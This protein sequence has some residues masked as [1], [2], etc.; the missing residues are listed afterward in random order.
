MT[1]LQRFFNLLRLDKKDIVQIFSYAIFSGL[2]SLSL[3]LGIQAIINFIQA[4]RISVSWIVLVVLV[5]IGVIFAGILSLMQLR[6]SENLQQKIFI[7]AA[8]EFAY[9]IPKLKFNEI[10]NSQTSELANRFFDTISIQKGTSKLLID[11]SSAFLQIFFGII[12]LSLYHPF[13]ILFGIFLAILLYL[14]FKFSYQSGLQTSLKE[15]KSKYKVANWLFELA[16]NNFSFK[17]PNHLEFALEKNNSLVTKYLG[18]REKHFSV[19]KRQFSQLLIFK[20]LIT[21]SLLLIGG[22][23]VINQ[24][25]NIGQFVAAEIIILLVINSVEKIILGLETFYDVLTSVEKIGQITD[26]DLEPV[27][28]M[29]IEN[30]SCFS[31]LSITL[32]NVEFKFEFENENVLENIDLEI[33]QGERILIEGENGSGKTTLIRLLSGLLQ[34]TKGH[35]IIN[36]DTYNKVN[37]N[38]YRKHFG[39]I[40]YGE[41]LFEGTILENIAFNQKIENSKLKWALE[42]VDLTSFIKTLPLGLQTPISSDGK[43]LSSSNM[44]KILIARSIINEPRILFFENA[45]DKTDSETAKKII[46]FLLH[47]D[48]KWTIIAVSKNEYF[49]EKCSRIITLNEGKIS[50]DFKKI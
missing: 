8:F 17:N 41:S 2:I 14:I 29:S 6:I 43:Q 25:M 47:N 32:E 19:I 50:K 35:F 7:R 13:F 27:E 37:I 15:S 9:R 42:G 31:N 34:P 28:E 22:F 5:V 49:K 21:T 44:Q 23:L 38:D 20:A 26:L 10:H 30:N 18:Y 16:K 12:L 4:G 40:L 24:K 48:Q 45:L 36:D 39:S 3:P 11:F 33:N 46:D 1:P